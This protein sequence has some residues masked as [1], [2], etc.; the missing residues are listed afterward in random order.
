MASRMTP[1]VTEP[2]Y[3]GQK[4][5]KMTKNDTN[6]LISGYFQVRHSTSIRASV[7]WLIGWSVRWLIC[8]LVDWLVSPL[9][10]LSVG[11]SVTLE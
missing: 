8:P 6:A 2:P 5:A 11:W 10:D 4:W 9:V 1:R 7:R 3:R